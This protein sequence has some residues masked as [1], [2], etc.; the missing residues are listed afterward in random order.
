MSSSR[1][2]IFSLFDTLHLPSPQSP[3]PTY[4]VAYSCLTTPQQII[5]HTSGSVIVFTG[6]VSF[7]P[8]EKFFV[9][10]EI[11]SFVMSAKTNPRQA[12][13]GDVSVNIEDVI[14]DRPSLEDH[15]TGA[16][17]NSV[18]NSE[19]NFS[20]RSHHRHGEVELGIGDM[21]AFQAPALA[22][23]WMSTSRRHLLRQS[24]RED[25]ARRLTTSTSANSNS[26]Q[27]SPVLNENA[28]LIK[29]KRGGG[30]SGQI[31]ELDEDEG[32][33]EHLEKETLSQALRDIVFGKI[34]SFLLLAG[35]FAWASHH[36]AWDSAW[37]RQKI[38]PDG[39]CG[40]DLIDWGI[41]RI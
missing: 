7:I 29:S 25:S 33:G 14:S 32:S 18:D 5:A 40:Y 11:R 6:G 36:F 17:G 3:T 10:I 12:S 35:P 26:L 21:A 22:R 41:F 20:T 8:I 38:V 19:A 9:E 1:S 23:R 34:V 28:P 2:A 16:G 24:L 31:P 30:G 39:E 27:G 15:R 37:V 4:Y 13:V